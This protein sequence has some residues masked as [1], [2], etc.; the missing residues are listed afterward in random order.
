VFVWSR[1][2]SPIT[3]VKDV[4]CVINYDLP[5]NIEDYIHRIGRT[6]RAG[7]SGTA[8][9][10]FTSK[11]AGKARELIDILE[12]AGQDVDPKLREFDH[13]SRGSCKSRFVSPLFLLVSVL[14]GHVFLVAEP[15]PRSLVSR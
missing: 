7:A 9:A 13:G 12:E 15:Y 2:P 3:D 6:A 10:F 4:A 1:P 14:S 8:Y 5:N 11:N